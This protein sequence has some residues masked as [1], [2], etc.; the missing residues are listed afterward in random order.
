MSTW[1]AA[2][3]AY[4]F[5]APGANRSGDHADRAHGVERPAFEVLAGDIFQRLP[6]RPEIDAVAHLGIA[7]HGCNFR[8]QKV[9]HH[10]RN[11]I[12][13]DDG[14]GIDANKNFRID[15][16]FKSKVERLGLAGVGSGKNQ[17]PAGRFFCGKRPG[18]R[19]PMFDLWSRRR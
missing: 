3:L 11:R 9:R 10:A 1:I 8:I 12:G 6:A 5:D 19:F 17:Y 14:V 15:D 7:R 18:G 16:V 13:S 4:C 2:G